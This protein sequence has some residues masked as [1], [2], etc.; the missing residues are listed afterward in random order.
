VHLGALGVATELTLAIEPTFEV[1]QVVYEHLPWDQL[2]SS[3]QEVMGAGY[4]VSAITDFAGDDVDMLWVKSRVED[5][6]WAGLPDEL[7]GARAA[8]EK[9]H[10]T[11]GN[12]PLTCRF[13][14]ACRGVRPAWSLPQ[15][16]SLAHHP[17]T[18]CALSSSKGGGRRVPN[19][20]VSR[21]RIHRCPV[22]TALCG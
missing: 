4:S 20:P 14:P 8:A 11:P 1:R 6:A 17:W 22:P 16:L 3:F 2:T 13:P 21:S 18:I 5:D 15:P 12:D 7:F 10:V 19:R 9:L